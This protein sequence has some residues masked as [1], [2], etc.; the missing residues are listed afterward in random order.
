MTA[1][2][3]DYLKVGLYIPNGDGV[4]S[5]DIKHWSDIIEVAVAAEQTGFDSVWVADHM[6][7]R[8]GEKPTEGRWEC[9]TILA[10]LAVATK[11][12]E[13][14][15]LVSCMAFRNP[16]LLAKMAVTV[17][18]ISG[19]RLILALGAGWHEPEFVTYD[20]PYDHR[21]SRFEEGFA[22]SSSL[23]RDGEIDFHGKYYS[24]PGCEIRP[25][26]PRGATMPIF[27]G[28]DGERMLK[29]TVER[30]D[31]WNTVWSRSVE[32]IK[33][34]LAAVDAACLAAGRDPVTLIRSACVFVDLPGARGAVWDP[35]ESSAPN[36][37]QPDEAAAL[38]RSYQYAG[39]DHVM[40][41]LDPCTVD[42][43]QAFGA[44][45]EILRAGTPS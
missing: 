11:R 31:G 40:L 37:L 25:R 34:R 19:G 6:I 38:L 17:D 7:F 28:T 21:A 29:L 20:F 23:I 36:P 10:A 30:A 26:G 13:I 8:F 41:W 2:G 24:A 45:L 14:G 12:V 27:I 4:M 42:A 22:I 3:K 5:P 15:P 39:I 44:T 18:E 16:A 1:T 32:E 43:V 33:P 9:W 35:G